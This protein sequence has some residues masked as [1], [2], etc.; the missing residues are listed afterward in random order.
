MIATGFLAVSRRFG[1]DPQNY[2]HLT[3]EDT[4]DTVGK[5]ILGLTISCGRCHDHKFDPISSKDYYALYGI[6]ESTLYPFPGSEEKKQQRDF[7]SLE[8]ERLAAAT[9][10]FQS[11]LAVLQA[12]LKQKEL[13][14]AELQ[15]SVDTVGKDTAPK[16]ATAEETKRLAEL[17]A[18]L[19]TAENSRAQA[20]KKLDEHAARP[21][22]LAKAYAVSES[23]A[24][25]ARI[26]KRGDPLTP[27]DEVP[28]R[29]PE[30][31]GGL[32]LPAGA[33]GSGRLQLAQW[34]TD[35][36]NPLT[37]RVMVNRIWQHH[38]GQG[39]VRTPS[40]FGK[41]GRAPTHP[42]LLDYLAARFIDSG[43]SVKSMHKLIMRSQAYQLS[44]TVDSK[45]SASDPAN[46]LLSHFHRRRL[47][48][49]EI[50]DS[51]LVLGG[52]LDATMAGPHPFPPQQSWGFTQHAP[53]QA[54]YDTNR[55]SVYLMTQR[56]R[57]HP[58]LAL[59]DGPDT[60]SSTASRFTTTVP[61]QALYF[62][63]NP[64]VHEQAA[65]FANRISQS[66]ADAPGRIE[67]GYMMAFGRPPSADEMQSALVFLNDIATEAR[68][69][70][71]PIQA[72]WS[73]FARLLFS[74]NEFVHID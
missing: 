62:M 68:T 24:K 64:F 33:S 60:N 18:K 13:A 28:R 50:R 9:N 72:V 34:L 58:F 4:I 49:E 20:K 29:F 11:K 31:L 52:N 67:A 74:S 63:N 41:Q 70:K 26:H 8:P 15:K 46:E 45:A 16:V 43:W 30:I 1:F 59:F 39:L 2:H 69:N 36:K 21:P 12:E 57:R 27:G 6:F 7:M 66:H 17:R 38:F 54:V 19:A 65:K 61:T 25:N 53:F 51:L 22:A 14:K 35:P 47:D 37:A 48:A 56:I 42:E 3:I 10:E 40:N 71:V 73:S 23:A 32:S 5:S 44:S 55:R